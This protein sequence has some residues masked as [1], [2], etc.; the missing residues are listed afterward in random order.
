MTTTE[1]MPAGP[2]K[3][4]EDKR[5]GGLLRQRDFR[6]LWTGETTSKLGS[7][8]GEMAL[9]L[10]AVV[11]LDADTF[12]VG[13]LTA[14]VWLPWLLFGLLAGVWVDR[15]DART[16]MIVSNVVSTLLFLSVPVATWLDVLTVGQLLTV[17][18]LG[19]TASVCFT[20][21]YRTYLPS[22]VRKEDLLEANTKLQGSEAA[23]QV[24]GPGLGGV[25]AQVLGAV[26]GILVDSLTF[27]F[28]A[29]CIR[30]IRPAGRRPR[31]N[32]RGN[33]RGEI[34]D[35]VR[36]VLRDPYLRTLM[37]FGAVSNIALNGFQSLYV[38][39]LVRTVG[40]DSGVVGVLFGV[41]GVGGVCG[42]LLAGRLAARVGTARA[43]LLCQLSAAP[44]ALLIPMTGPG[45]ALL[46]MAIGGFCIGVGVVGSGVI[47]VSFRQS[48]IPSEFLGRVTAS[49]AV[50]NYGA[51]PIGAA[52]GG[53]LGTA[54]GIRTTMWITTLAF[55]LACL[56]L[57]ASPIRRLR[58]FPAA[59]P[60][61]VQPAVAG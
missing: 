59:P 44:T 61:H 60:E 48:Y 31:S 17:A 54:L 11:T 36:F 39:F 51:I 58:D 40:V 50:I 49:M 15:L 45:Y 8:V 12:T 9:P 30:G 3:R 41:L 25:V 32:S 27:L 10:V 53:F 13:L 28:S 46:F 2:A 7:A 43:M 5:R 35:G 57:V 47:T 34:A 21:A 16:V 37:I 42:A 26:S 14:A 38:V 29:L 6:L 23:A 55:V 56:V 20:T 1:P 22:L 18:F 19:G 52:L 24:V 33:L 4:E